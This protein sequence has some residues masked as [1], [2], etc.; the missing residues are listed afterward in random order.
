MASSLKAGDPVWIRTGLGT[1]EEPGTVVSVSVVGGG[2][3]SG[4]GSHP[5]AVAAKV[6]DER[7]RRGT[8]GT[9]DVDDGGGEDRG[10]GG[11]GGGIV[12]KFS[13]SGYESAIPDVDRV[14]PM[15]SEGDGGGRRRSRRGGRR[16]AAPRAAVTPSPTAT[17]AE[18]ESEPPR[19]EGDAGDGDEKPAAARGGRK[20]EAAAAARDAGPRKR[21]RTSSDGSGSGGGGG[22]GA[23]RTSAPYFAEGGAGQDGAKDEANKGRAS[24]GRGRGRKLILASSEDEEE[25]EKEGEDGEEKMGEPEA[26]KPAAKRAAAKAPA[27]KRAAPSKPAAKKAASKKAAAK[28]ESEAPAKK[29]AAKKA[30]EIA[31]KQPAAKRA[32]AKKPAEAAAKKPAAKKAAAS[33]PAAKKPA[34]ATKGRK[35]EAGGDGSNA[36]KKARRAFTPVVREADER[37]HAADPADAAAGIR[38]DGHGGLNQPVPWVVEYAKT[39]RASCRTC[40]EKIGKGEVRVGHTPLF[41]GKPGFMV[42]RHLHCAVFSEEIACAE[43]VENYDALEE[44]DYVKLAE[45]VDVSKEKI[46]EE[47]E[48]L[49][50]DE[51]IQKRFEGEIR[52]EPPGLNATLLPF[53]VEGFSWMRH[54]ELQEEARGGI[55]A[56]EMG[57]G[58][59]IQ[60]IAAILDRMP[61]LQHAKPGMKHPPTGD[62]QERRD[63]EALWEGAKRDWSN[64]MELLKVPKKLRLRDGGARAGTLVICPVIALSQWKAEI[65]KFTEGGALKVCTYHGPDRE[66]EVPRELMKK[67]DVV[68]TTYQVLQSDFR[69]M[70]SPNRVECPNCGGKF[71]IDKL[72]IHLKYFCGDGAQRTEAQARQR[73]NSDGGGGG[74]GGMRR[75]RRPALPFGKKDT[76]KKKQAANVKEKTPSK[77]K[78]PMPAKKSQR[79]TKKPPAKKKKTKDADV[80]L[81]KRS[82]TKKQPK[83]PSKN[84]GARDDSE[85]GPGAETTPRAG[86]R[87]SAALRA[88]SQISRSAAEWAPPDDDSDG[89]GFSSDDESSPDDDSS[90]GGESSSD[91]SDVDSDSSSD[92]SA[93]ERAREKQRRALEMSKGGKKQQA[94][95]KAFA[96]EKKGKKSFD[97]KPAAKGQKGKAKKK[98]DYEDSDD[99]YSSGDDDS[100]GE[101]ADDID[102]AGLMEEAMAGAKNSVLHS[103]SWWR[104]VLDE[105]HFIKTRSSQTA[106]AAFSLIG[107]HR[108]CL[109]GTPLQNRVGEFY[110][111]VR[112]L[113]L[114]PMAYYYCRAKG[115]DCKSLHYRIHAG[116][117][118]CCGHSGIQHYSHFNKYIL[119]PIQRDGYSGDGRRAMFLLKD[120]VLDK[121]L[122]RRT[123]ETKAADMELPPRLVQIKPVRLHP[124]EED[125]YSAL[126]TQTKSSFDDY[127]DS[128]TL[129]NNYAHIFDLLIRMRQSVDHPYLVLFSKKNTDGQMGSVTPG[130]APA[131]ANGS[132]DCDLCHEPPTER[133]LASCCGAA[134]CRACVLEYMATSNSIAASASM[135]CPSCRGA[136]SIDLQARADVEDD[137]A[138][139]VR[140]SANKSNES[141]AGMPS[142]RELQHVATGSVLR[143]INLANFATSSK[144]EALTRELV[145]MRQT[146]P[147]SKAIV[148]SQFVNMLD[149]IRWRLHSDPY[150]EDIGLGCRALH[151][152]MNVKAR[153]SCLKEFREDN[154]V[155]VLLMSLKAG[156]VALNLTCANYI[157][158]MDPWWNPAAEM[159]AIDRTHRIGQYRPIR[160]VRFIAENTVEE[161]IL[162]L[163]EKKRLVFDGTV[164]RDAGS[165][166]MLT[167]DDMKSLF[168]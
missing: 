130:D 114:D 104:I 32:V 56:D 94:K 61:K 10:D 8:G 98:F 165:L 99:V 38:P 57:M 137:C 148:F 81:T 74:G 145:M 6:K 58:K 75:G 53:Q 107:V 136:F 150:L 82:A 33:K 111:L 52:R 20:R 134:Y 64:E 124:V 84:S 155:R 28:K 12:V 25:E 67:Y 46:K 168:A 153:D 125:F 152:G 2:V 117:C 21:A 42:Y 116:I 86:S 93:L 71:K 54:Q 29:P 65:E 166:K 113:R 115:C 31:A 37:C 119:N 92:D 167:V 78:K 1:H 158:L 43:D 70:T 4:S 39:G 131:I 118:Q 60:T 83:K 13:S 156:G 149:L 50:P 79:P 143:R 41:R 22:E 121:A 73:R 34:T 17:E 24:R 100:S 144:I 15:N 69:K 11:G 47:Q 141:G 163:Q 102:M 126:Y 16:S 90:S 30:G 135:T 59:T 76:K 142:L 112:F 161:R 68:L 151:G 91:E 147:G 105:A 14:R 19:G 26:K 110:S 123:K 106:N 77:Q 146:S 96:S 140:T 108:W 162:Q 103:L 48:E 127:A 18:A 87:R 133:V 72:H 139:T 157:Y 7:P 164:G 80:V 95:K 160:A 122:L 62:L 154:N 132:A 49:K 27:G 89:G 66:K 23:R 85:K 159:Q 129:L 101:G 3:G 35:K 5:P 120:E 40:D 51:L 36:K 128:G 9:T 55:L 63:E 44:D 109:S 138:L 97:K 88:A 45:Q